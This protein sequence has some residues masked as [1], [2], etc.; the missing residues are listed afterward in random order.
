V[1][2]TARPH[3]WLKN[4]LVVA[5]PGAAGVLFRP[6]VL[7]RTLIAFVAFCLVSSG[8]YLLNDAMDVHADRLH[9][10]KRHRP[11]ASG[12]VPVGLAKGAAAAFLA[13]GVGVGLVA[14]VWLAVVLAIYVVL[15]QAYSIAFKRVAVIELAIVS[16]GFVMRA[17]A[18]GV[19]TDIPISTWFLIVTSFAS[20]FIVVGKRHAEQMTLGNTAAEHRP[21]LDEYPPGFL[22][23][24]GA[25]S[26]AVAIISYCLWALLGVRADSVW[27]ELSIIPF[28]L[29]MLRYALLAERG[30]AGAPEDVFLGDRT[31]LVLG[32][33]W[34]LAFGVGIYVTR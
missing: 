13:A 6:E 18:G 21:A 19:A 25:V 17:I 20:L 23:Y 14:N 27:F 11:I 3:Q 34:A 10:R 1:L 28:V 32:A 26:A 33:L 4:V 30:E 9:P 24:V 16:S 15:M 29:A 12:V 5:A 22:Q 8:T 2:R 31:V 7:G